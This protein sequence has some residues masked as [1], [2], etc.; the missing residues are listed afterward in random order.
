MPHQIAFTK[1]RVSVMNETNQPS[2]EQTKCEVCN[3]EKAPN[4]YLFP[5][6]VTKEKRYCACIPWKTMKKC[7][8]LSLLNA[9]SLADDAVSS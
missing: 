5:E 6:D 2:K 7:A 3:K 8:E 4:N 1:E 9:E